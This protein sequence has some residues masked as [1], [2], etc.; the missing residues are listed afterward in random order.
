MRSIPSEPL[1]TLP[2]K[3]PNSLKPLFWDVRFEQLDGRLDG[4]FVAARLL[5]SG[6]WQ[7]IL[8]LCRVVGDDALQQLVRQR[9]GRGLS[10]GQL[11]FWQIRWGLPKPLVD[12]WIQSGN[13]RTKLPLR[14]Q[15]LCAI[16]WPPSNP[17]PRR[18]A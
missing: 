16:G 4:D 8:W 10:R 3:L 2:R 9:G 15:R 11:R 1:A 18:C 17:K 7:S 14:L 12:E 5:E 13:V 6:S